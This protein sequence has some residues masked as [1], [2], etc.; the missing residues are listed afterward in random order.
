[1]DNSSRHHRFRFSIRSLMIAVAVCA[2][3]L[4]PILWTGRNQR[5]LALAEM[6]AMN[7]ELRARADMAR[8]RALAASGLSAAL[9]VNHSVFTF[10]DVKDLV[11]EFTIV[12][13]GPQTI[14]PGIAG[15]RLIINGKEIEDSGLLLGNGPRDARFTALPPGDLIRFTTRLG[16]QF[17]VP[18]TYHISWRGSQFRT[19]EIPIRVLPVRSRRSTS[20]YSKHRVTWLPRLEGPWYR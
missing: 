11:V 15:S 10:D 7:A 1:M 14:D 4:L 9:N 2:L 18:G 12:N 17:Q 5:L 16:D 6:R 13:D 8:A 20:P 19:L 3:V